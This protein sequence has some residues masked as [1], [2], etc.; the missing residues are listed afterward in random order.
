MF[1]HDPRL[2]NAC[3]TFPL[4][5]V[6]PESVPDEQR[7]A[8][9]ARAQQLA[10]A[11]LDELLLQLD[12]VDRVCDLNVSQERQLTIAAKGVVQQADWMDGFQS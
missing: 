4:T 5:D 11:M 1:V 6:V 9:Q 2:D 10:D 8:V 3:G 7:E 12:E